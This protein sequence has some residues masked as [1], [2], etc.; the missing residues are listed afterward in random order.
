MKDKRRKK[1]PAPAPPPTRSLLQGRALWISAAL[2]LITVAVYAPVRHYGFVSFDDPQ[3]V[4]EN[5]DV[6]AG[7]TAHGIRWAFTTG[8]ASNWHP[9]TWLSHMADVQMFGLNAGPQHL[10]NVVFHIANTLLL[11]GLLYTMTGALGRSGFV[12][13]LFA[14]HPLHVES[15]A[16]IAERKDVLSTLLWMLTIWA[17]V[18]YVRQPRAARFATVVLAFGLGLMAK[19]MLVTLPFVL[20]LLD[21]W[22][23]GRMSLERSAVI[24]SV[25]EKT[26]LIAMAVAASVVTFAVQ[27]R[28]GAVAGLDAIPPGLRTANAL[29]SYTAYMWKMFWPS[30][31]TVLYPFP[32]SIPAWQVAGSVVALMGISLAAL[33]QGRRRPYIPVGWLWFLGTL[34]PVIGFVQVGSQS[35]ADRYTYV[36]LIGLSIIAAWGLPDLA[37]RVRAKPALLTAAAVSLLAACTWGARQ[38]VAYWKDSVTLWSRALNVT[39][40]NYR[41]HVALGSLLQEGGKAGDATAHFQEALRL[42]PDYAEA[43][44]K[45]GAVLADEGRTAE[46]VPHFVEAIRLKRDL[47]E[48]HNNLGNASARQ[49]KLEEAIAHYHDALRWKPDDVAAHNGLGS[50]LDDQGK[51][52]EAIAQYA[53]AIR[54]DPA[55]APAHNNMGASLLKQGK[56]EEAVREFR[57]SIRLDPR[58]TS[59]RRNLDVALAELAKRGI[60][61]R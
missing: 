47:F 46:A 60:T 10:T 33:R 40:G 35:M 61:P 39:D 22:P 25:K 6:S 3:Y 54:I 27:R 19:P 29:T 31:L 45:L 28:G 4:S 32:K 9:L 37:A 41:A 23:L 36:P 18:A 12:A 56:A 57:E 55:H 50:A 13:A 44:N 21:V 58:N 34:V 51:F 5:P 1:P 16:W 42:R 15:V 43:H 53:E 17:Y 48:A 38:Q 2:I 59:Y 7:L 24:K 8:H 52:D 49:G 26:P 14:V 11:F 20:V 30:G